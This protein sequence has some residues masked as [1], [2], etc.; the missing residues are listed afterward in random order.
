MNAGD[1]SA[2]DELLA[3]DCA[4][5]EYWGVMDAAGMMQQLTAL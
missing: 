3:D 4:L 5:A 1:L 2:V